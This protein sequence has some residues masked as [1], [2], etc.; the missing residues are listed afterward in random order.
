PGDVAN[1]GRAAA[2]AAQCR[3]AR[4]ARPLRPA[5]GRCR[6]RG[7]V[8]ADRRRSPAMSAREQLSSGDSPGLIAYRAAAG[9]DAIDEYSRRLRRELN[10]LGVA[11]SYQPGGLVRA[12][13]HAHGRPWTLL[14][15]NPFAYGRSGVAPRVVP[16][17]FA[18]RRR[19][20]G[21]LA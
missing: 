8:R 18:L 13:E 6:A 1:A 7:S 2:R 12:R 3:G 10:A 9:V 14:Q 5:R 20:D 15:Y 4:R 17:A 16:D 19:T 11:S 21:P